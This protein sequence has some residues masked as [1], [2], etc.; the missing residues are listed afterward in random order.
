MIQVRCKARQCTDEGVNVV[1]T[2]YGEGDRTDFILSTSAYARLA[3]PNMALELFASGVVGV[4]YRRV[5][6]RYANYNVMFKIHEHSKFPQYLALVLLYQG[7]Q[8]D[9]LDVQMWQV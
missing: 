9:I 2:D 8:Y 3:R 7:G 5:S 1:A 4:E 6:C